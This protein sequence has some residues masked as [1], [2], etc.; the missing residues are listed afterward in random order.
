MCWSMPMASTN[1]LFG[2]KVASEIQVAAKSMELALRELATGIR[3]R[4]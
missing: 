2:I 3:M 4:V 1:T